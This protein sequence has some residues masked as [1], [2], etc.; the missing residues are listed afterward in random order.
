M[1]QLPSMNATTKR[2]GLVTR[3][4]SVLWLLAVIFIAGGNYYAHHQAQQP[5]QC[6]PECADCGHSWGPS[7]KQWC[8]SKNLK[9]MK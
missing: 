5:R 9:E 8:K 3:S 6:P 1:S 2:G 4:G 7:N